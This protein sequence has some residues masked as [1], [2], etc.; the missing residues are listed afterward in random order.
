MRLIPY[1]SFSLYTGL[2]TD[3]LVQRLH[4]ETVQKHSYYYWLF[5]RTFAYFQGR[6]RSTGFSL[7]E[8]DHFFRQ[9]GYICTGRFIPE[10]VGTTVDVTIRPPW[11]LILFLAIYWYPFLIFVTVC[12][13]LSKLWNLDV[14]GILLTLWV[15]P[16]LTLII[17]FWVKVPQYRTQLEFLLRAEPLGTDE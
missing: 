4:E 7:K 8:V 9:P 6:V 12:I 17:S 11:A 1:T 15:S 14:L 16:W 3:E 2:D 5:H 10:S 13:L